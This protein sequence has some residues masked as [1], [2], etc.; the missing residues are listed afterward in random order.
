MHRGLHSSDLAHLRVAF[1]HG[2]NALATKLKVPTTSTDYKYR[3]KVPTEKNSRTYKLREHL[4]DV[5]D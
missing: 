5:I 1:P 3:L 4:A 2:N